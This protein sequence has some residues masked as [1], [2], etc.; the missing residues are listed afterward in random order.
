MSRRLLALSILLTGLTTFAAAAGGDGLERSSN[1][2]GAEATSLLGRKLA[3]PG[4]SS[5]SQARM[6]VQLAAAVSAWEKNRDDV[7]AL[8]WV[9]RRKY[10]RQGK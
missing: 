4:L 8:I 7:D 6:E 1:N 5:E 10:C 9:G 3:S 2:Q